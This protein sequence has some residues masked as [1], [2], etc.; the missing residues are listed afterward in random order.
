MRDEPAVKLRALSAKDRVELELHAAF[1]SDTLR[2]AAAV[3]ELAEAV[4]R[5]HFTQGDSIRAMRQLSFTPDVVVLD[6]MFPERTKSAQVRK[7][8]QLIHQLEAP[9]GDEAELMDAAR[10]AGS[11]R[12]VVK[13]PLK[14]PFLADVKPSYSLKGKAVRYDCIV[15]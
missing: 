10:A 3:P 12:I 1:L 13:R 7:K 15:L 8:F 9:C 5:M 4:G 6:P 14:G 11:R 2:R